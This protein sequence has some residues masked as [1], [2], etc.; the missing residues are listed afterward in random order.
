[1]TRKIIIISALISPLLLVH[2]S[3][4]AQLFKKLVNSVKQSVSNKAS[5]KTDSALSNNIKSN[6]DTAATN[7]VLS[8]FAKAARDNP[9]DTSGAD[10]TTKALGNLIG[11]GGVSAADS[12]TAI[13][14]FMSANGGSGFYYE[15]STTVITKERG[16]VNSK[17]K[18][19]FTNAG[20]G[21]AEVNLAAMM[22]VKN[23]TPIT[24]V[25][26]AGYQKYSLT[27]DEKSK[28]YSLNIIDTSLINRNN[29]TYT[30]TKIGYETVQGFNCIHSKLVS[31]SKGMFKSSSTMEVW[32]STTVPGYAQLKKLMTSQ[33]ITPAMTQAFDKAGCG[34]YF[35]KIMMTNKNFSLTTILTTAEAKTFPAS[36]FKIPAGYSEAKGNLMIGKMMQVGAKN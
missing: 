34:G 36:L 20:E 7:S 5:G 4:Q 10:L 11:G 27:L 31:N 12:A 8:A 9:N 17:N 23:E 33:N 14:M 26:R 3:L 6:S 32:T 15:T 2:V 35:V 22:G 18:S 25:S 16:T 13:K 29:E 28:A 19:Y 24:V 21:R 30:V 1:M